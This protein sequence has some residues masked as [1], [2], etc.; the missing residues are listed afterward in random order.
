MEDCKSIGVDVLGPDVNESQYA[1][2]VNEKGQIRFGLGAIKGIGE[3]PSEAIVAARKNERYKNIYDFFEKIPSSQMNKRVAESLV[4][5]G[6][7]DEIDRYH[8]AQYFDIDISGRTNIEKLLRYG[9]SFQ[10]NINEIENS[11]FADFADEVKIEQPKI[12]PAPEWQNMHKLNKEKEIIG[13]YLS[14]HPL[15]EYK[16]QYQ[17]IQGVLSK[18]EILEGKKDEVAEL[19]KIIIPIDVADETSDVDEDLIDLPAEITDGE[20]EILIEETGKKVEPKG[21]YNFL[22]LDEIEAFKNTVFA[23]QQPDLF[24]NDKLSWKEKQALKNNTPE[25]MVAG[26][27]T[28]YSVRDGKNSGEKIAFITLEDYSG[29]YGFRLGD[30]DYMRLR[31]K[32][33]VQ[34]F[35]IFKIKFTQANDG[36]VFVNVSEVNDLKDAF[37]KLAKKLTVVVDVNHLRRE[38]IEFFKENFVDNHGD[39]KLNFFIKNPEDQSS[40]EVVSMKANIEINGN[41]LKIIHDMQ[42]FEVFLN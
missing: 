36:R 40:M 32:I 11:L 15:D 25:Y 10:D 7:F 27:V 12:N 34:R 3:G 23:N 28:E 29:S 26:L 38:D 17:F 30:R 5:A 2:A 42:K 16:F 22:N 13:F 20:E 21:A 33:D 9:S 18:K 31:E 37:E 41:L 19:E 4:V 39:Q 35:V 8:R 6:A 24:N 1:F 14:A